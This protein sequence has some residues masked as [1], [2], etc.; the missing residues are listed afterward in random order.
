MVAKYKTMG[1]NGSDSNDDGDCHRYWADCSQAD[2]ETSRTYRGL[3][4]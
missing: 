4:E 2:T 3:Q 1:G